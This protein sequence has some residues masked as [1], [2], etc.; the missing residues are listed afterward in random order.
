MAEYQFLNTNLPRPRITTPQITTPGLQPAPLSR[1]PTQFDLLGSIKGAFREP[2][3]FLAGLIP[4]GRKL[5][6]EPVTPSQVFA[7]T[8]GQLLREIPLIAAAEAITGTVAPA[9]ETYLPVKAATISAK[10]AKLGRVG[11]LVAP[12]VGPVAR[13]ALLGGTLGALRAT[14]EM[15]P[16]KEF[17]GEVIGTAGIF[18]PFGAKGI[19]GV[20]PRVALGSGAALAIEAFRAKREGREFT[21][22]EQLLTLALTVPFIAAGIK[23]LNVPN[24]ILRKAASS[25]D[26]KSFQQSLTAADRQLI[27]EAKLTARK[28]YDETLEKVG[29][30]F[31]KAQEMGIE[32]S[33][34]GT[35][36]IT[37]R[38]ARYLDEFIKV[39]PEE[40][41]VRNRITGFIAEESQSVA[42]QERD[43]SN[44]NARF[45]EIR[46]NFFSNLSRRESE[47]L[48]KTARARVESESLDS[49]RKE[50]RNYLQ[51]VNVFNS[52]LSK[53]EVEVYRAKLNSAKNSKDIQ[54][55]VTEALGDLWSK[56]KVST[57]SK[58]LDLIDTIRTSKDIVPKS[59]HEL[60]KFLDIYLDAV[61]VSRRPQDVEKYLLIN[62]ILKMADDVR[63]SKKAGR[64]AR[65]DFLQYF[66]QFT[67]EKLNPRAKK[68][69]QETKR[70][71][72]RQVAKGEIPNLPKEVLDRIKLL[73][74]TPL[75]NLPISR[76]EEVFE[77]ASF[78]S[79]YALRQ[80]RE[81]RIGLQRVTG[82]D[83]PDAI[84]SGTKQVTTRPQIVRQEGVPENLQGVVRQ[85]LQNFK[86]LVKEIDVAIQPVKV[87]LDTL[88]GD[89]GYKG[90]LNSVLF[91]FS[92]E[93]PKWTA[94]KESIFGKFKKIVDEGGMKRDGVERITVT[95]ILR[96]GGGMERLIARGTFDSAEEAR[97][98][99][100]GIRKAFEAL[101]ENHPEKELDRLMTDVFEMLQ[102][103]LKEVLQKDLGEDLG[104]IEKYNPFMLDRKLSLD[105]MESGEFKSLWDMLKRPEMAEYRRTAIK[106]AFGSAKAR[107]EA[108][109][110][111]AID[112]DR[113]FFDYV[114]DALYIINMGKRLERIRRFIADPRIE[115]MYGKDGKVILGKLLDNLVKKGGAGGSATVPWLDTLR[116]KVGVGILGFRI[117]TALMQ[118]TSL[119]NAGAFIGGGWTAK[120]AI[121]AFDRDLAKFAEAASSQL[122]ARATT[123]DDPS[124]R[125]YL[126]TGLFPDIGQKAVAASFEAL[127]FGDSF[128]A[129]ATWLGA[130]QKWHADRGMRADFKVAPVR[131][132]VHY[133]DTVLARSQAG[134]SFMDVP[135]AVSRG[136][137]PGINNK[138]IVK[139]MLQF[140]NF[141]LN[142]WSIVRHDIYR[143][144]I[145]AGNRREAANK[146]F[147]V[148]A[149]VSAAAGVSVG[150]NALLRSFTGEDRDRKEVL[151]EYIKRVFTESTQTVPFAAPFVSL[152]TYNSLPIPALD[153]II[154]LGGGFIDLSQ[155]RSGLA[156]RRALT[157]FI[158]PA[159]SLLGIPG[160]SQ[161]SQITQRT[162]SA[163][164][165]PSLAR[166]RELR[167][168]IR[169][170][171]RHPGLDDN[172]KRLMVER[173]QERINSIRS[174]P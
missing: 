31:L 154:D 97:A 84:L 123:I 152:I 62:R 43:I 32:N 75:Q 47:N 68:E 128:A 143:L 88:D 71:F 38:A 157:R 137:F 119:F 121:Q 144:G 59:R 42:A 146:A 64:A 67:T 55:V 9:L 142:N 173:L 140:Q 124:F 115:S 57:F 29:R 48:S 22:A 174:A 58:V 6:P 172:V 11:K 90:F 8:G 108:L 145:Q 111:I 44:F 23:D 162:I 56:R 103:R 21:G 54:N 13:E 141:V 77:R 114:D 80:G 161:L 163:Q 40:S 155:A 105:M 120:G 99:Y 26:F 1:R 24:S 73:R 147:W 10:L 74:Q 30:D 37:N 95:R 98:Y 7:R 85:K 4:F 65:E 49:Y 126:A 2:K 151:D 87:L 134:V 168:R 28:L 14:A 35:G 118:P 136:D 149:G 116:R 156:K 135:M 33:L 5:A 102:K 41:P 69:I 27:K 3:Q 61:I 86:S 20:L 131:D 169:A 110:P 17:P 104:N 89:Q 153:A 171:N 106:E 96:Q 166:V 34:T 91:N 92:D 19:S 113:I 127:R 53:G 12:A 107:T 51:D 81:F 16:L 94:E 63:A 167:D 125:E 112:G 129:R 83:V 25:R 39:I 170:I 158:A 46:S 70:F 52:K 36:S 72:D 160:S 50:L 79:G 66:E 133:A 15:R 101:P 164:S 139:A 76:L 117:A 130:Y 78:L 159:G 60:R 148:F 132:A 165:N 109:R 82:K 45:R 122:K 150:T 100:N 18:A 93:V 138:S